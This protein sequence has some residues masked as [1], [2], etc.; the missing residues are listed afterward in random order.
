MFSFNKKNLFFVPLK[1]QM[2]LDP[3]FNL[4]RVSH[5][6]H[7]V[8]L[9]AKVKQLSDKILSNGKDP[10]KSIAYLCEH[11]GS[12]NDGTLQTMYDYI[13]EITGLDAEDVENAKKNEIFNL[14]QAVYKL[15][16]EIAQL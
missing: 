11:L 1:S 9:E 6:D 7:K 16:L 8:K 12:L 15:K 2:S 10:A 5:V 3:L 14:V 4:K 13:L